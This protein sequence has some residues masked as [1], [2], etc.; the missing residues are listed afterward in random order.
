LAAT[1]VF[2]IASSVWSDD[3]R[4][5]L[6][7]L[8]AIH[9]DVTDALFAGRLDL[10]NV[11]VYGHSWGGEAADITMSR[12]ERFSAGINVDGT[13][14]VE[15]TEGNPKITFINDYFEPDDVLTRQFETEV[16]QYGLRFTGFRHSTFSDCPLWVGVEVVRHPGVRC[17]VD[18][19]LRAIEVTNAFIRGFFD[20]HL[21]GEVVPF[22]EGPSDEYPEVVFISADD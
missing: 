11:G 14:Y 2:D 17:V 9:T 3:Q 19:P 15:S 8:E 6:N 4:F 22:L 12:D 18:N 1:A 20:Q 10:E 13:S 5:V 7:Q 16:Y 21:K